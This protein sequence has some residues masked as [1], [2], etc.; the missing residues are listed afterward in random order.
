M[1]KATNSSKGS[2]K[3]K[4]KLLIKRKKKN[5]NNGRKVEKGMHYLYV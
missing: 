1:S 4:L 2:K 3:V 5:V